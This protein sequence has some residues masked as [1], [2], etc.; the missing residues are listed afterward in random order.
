MDRIDQ[1]KMRLQ[2]ATK[3][4]WHWWTS[5]S[6]RRLK[7]ETDDFECVAVLTPTKSQSDGHPDCAIQGADMELI[8]NAP[9]DIR[10]LLKLV[11]LYE[12][13][14]TGYGFTNQDFVEHRKLVLD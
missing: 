3:G 9:G 13:V 12:Q 6:W 11:E 14:L 4:R 7:S 5:N 8:E 10:H 1:I 2:R